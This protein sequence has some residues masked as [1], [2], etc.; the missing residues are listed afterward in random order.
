M[1]EDDVTK[2][3]ATCR[4]EGCGNAGYPIPVFADT[5]DPAVACGPC[6]NLITDLEVVA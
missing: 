4:T 1:I 5:V 3:V 6:G 2:Y